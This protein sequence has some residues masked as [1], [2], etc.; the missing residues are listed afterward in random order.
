MQ[1]DRKRAFETL[2]SWI[3]RDSAN[4]LQE[5]SD[6]DIEAL[7]VAFNQLSH[8]QKTDVYIGYQQAL[9]A[10]DNLKVW[11]LG[12]LLDGFPLGDDS[13]RDFQR[14]LILQGR[15]VFTMATTDPDGIASL[16]RSR[17]DVPGVDVYSMGILD[18][19]DDRFALA[20]E[21][22]MG[23]E[24]WGSSDSS[25]KCIKK[26]LPRLWNLLGDSFNWGGGDEGVVGE[27]LAECEI[28]GIGIV[29]IG[30]RLRHKTK[31]F[32]M[33]VLAVLDSERHIL[34]VDCGGDDVAACS[35]ESYMYE[36]V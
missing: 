36:R 16:L 4:R 18:E 24:N 34:R 27:A 25:P 26:N 11:E 29:R 22:P 28:P 7:D 20:A 1:V 33:V 19:F 32:V 13:F 10:T 23:G 3:G 8:A 6:D 2:W 14:W 12:S 9:A 35:V 5:V 17:E 31:G 30:D 21:I 15:T